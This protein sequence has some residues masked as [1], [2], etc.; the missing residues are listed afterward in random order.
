MIVCERYKWRLKMAS[1]LK[2]NEKHTLK[3][4]LRTHTLTI[5]SWITIGDPSIAEIMAKSGF[6]WLT[7]DME[8]SAITLHEAQQLIQVIELSGCV[9]LVRVGNNDPNLIKRVM[10]AGAHGVIVPMV[11]NAKDAELAVK[12]VKYPPIGTRGVGLARAQGYGVDFEKYKYWVERES[13][14]IVQIE[15]I[16]AVNNIEEIILTEGVDGFIIGP[17]DLSGSLGIPGEFNDPKVTESLEKVKKAAKKA[18]IIS[19]FHVVPPEIDLLEAKIEEGYR[20]LGYS[21]DSLFLAEACRTDLD[22]IHR[23]NKL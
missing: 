19:G 9:P 21:L 8:H 23:I 18:N 3:Y 13:I 7:V 12:A 10:D 5:G 16:D 4:K 6:D 1:K 20:F 2:L 11:N 17:Y 22:K 15:H 14:V